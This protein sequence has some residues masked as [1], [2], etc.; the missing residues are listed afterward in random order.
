MVEVAE[1]TVEVVG[2]GEEEG[3]HLVGAVGV[4]EGEGGKRET[5]MTVLESNLTVVR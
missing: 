3:V 1:V 5:E 4:E 2:E